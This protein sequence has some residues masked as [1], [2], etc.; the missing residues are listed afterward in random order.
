MFFYIYFIN[1]DFFKEFK[2]NINLQINIQFLFFYVKYQDMKKT[3]L[4]SYLKSLLK[5]K[6][7]LLVSSKKERHKENIR[8]MFHL[9]GIIIPCMVLFFTQK[10]A[11]IL[12]ILI[13]IPTLIA[14]YNNFALILKKFKYLNL[15][16]KLFREEELIKGK[17][18]GFSWLLLGILLTIPVFDKQLIALSIMVLVISDASAAL[19]GKNFGRIKICDP[20][21]LEGTIAFII[22]GI[23]T[24]ILFIKYVLQSQYMIDVF[25]IEQMKFNSAYVLISILFTSITELV[26]KKI[27]INDNFAV[28]ISFCLIYKILTILF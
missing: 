24:S 7:G 19:I 23:I 26:A 8:K 12:L 17:L 13:L 15:I 6:N 5:L 14:D 27:E 9:C 21:T 18:S 20:K 22:S 16:L 10:N 4:K 1:Q 11:I 2:K 25:K 3:T 28:P